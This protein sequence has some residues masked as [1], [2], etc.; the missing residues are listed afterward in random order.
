MERLQ[1]GNR[2]GREDLP[3]KEVAEGQGAARKRAGWQ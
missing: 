2:K 3:W 1:V